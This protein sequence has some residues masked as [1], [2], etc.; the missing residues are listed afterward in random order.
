MS[1]RATVVL[2]VVLLLLFLGGDSV[3]ERIVNGPRVGPKTVVADDG[4]IN[5]A[6]QDLARAAGLDLETYALARCLASEHGQDPDV[7]L[8]VV[9]W[10]VRNMAI[11]RGV[12]ISRLLTDGAGTNGDGY[13]GEQKAVA[14]TKYA[15]TKVDPCERHVRIASTVSAASQDS[16]PT[17]GAT[18]FY[19]PRAQDA[20]A[21][22]AA[23]GDARY[24]KYAGKDADYIDSTWS[25]PGGLYAGGAVP[26]VPPGIDSRV[27]TLWRAA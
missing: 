24:A 18:H 23:A 1:K 17:A 15:S 4:L 20:L 8:Y 9:A 27:L 25:A 6:P 26:V 16:D 2:V 7:Y 13:F 21:A 19:S 12:K 11:E 22:R 10:A 3:I 14:G 5:E